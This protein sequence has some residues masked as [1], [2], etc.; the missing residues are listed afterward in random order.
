MMR[1]TITTMHDFLHELTEREPN[2]E[3]VVR[4]RTEPSTKSSSTGVE[5]TWYLHVEYLREI[6][7]G[8][9]AMVVIQ[10]TLSTRTDGDTLKGIDEM[11][12]R[13]EHE[14]RKIAEVAAMKNITVV[15]NSRY[16]DVPF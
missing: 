12:T 8:L 4:W 5:T 15:A 10:E 1:I 3:S 9:R 2:L 11:T 14:L 6:T 7:P 13:Q 16:E